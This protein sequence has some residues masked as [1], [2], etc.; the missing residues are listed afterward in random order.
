MFIYLCVVGISPVEALSFTVVL[1][2]A[3]IPMAIEIVTTTTLALGSKELS[4]HGA[5]GKYC[6]RTCTSA[7]LNFFYSLREL[8]LL[9]LPVS[10]ANMIMLVSLLIINYYVM[11]CHVMSCHDM[12]SSYH[13]VKCLYVYG[14]QCFNGFHSYTVFQLP[15]WRPLKTWPACLFCALIKPA[16]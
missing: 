8:K 2:V 9:L 15:G 1:M 6:M 11:S 13:E 3:S 4:K 14:K 7:C 5:I 10:L 16:H 12:T